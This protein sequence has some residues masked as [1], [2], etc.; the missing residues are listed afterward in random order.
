MRRDVALAP[1]RYRDLRQSPVH[2]LL[3]IFSDLRSTATFS[4][5][6]RF[7]LMLRLRDG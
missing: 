4:V 7:G 1:I 5:D 2:L 3:P 6:L